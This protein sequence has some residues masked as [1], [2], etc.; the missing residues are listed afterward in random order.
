MKD[1]SQQIDTNEKSNDPSL[2]LNNQE[3][4]FLELI[5]RIIVR[6]SFEESHQKDRDII[7]YED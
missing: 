1:N 7:D 4:V 5:A 6:I 2:S 3:R